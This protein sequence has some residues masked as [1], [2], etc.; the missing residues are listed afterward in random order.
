M[1]IF[2]ISQNCMTI[3]LFYHT[4]FIKDVNYDSIC[5][6]YKTNSRIVIHPS[7]TVDEYIRSVL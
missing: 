1:H 3:R 4:Y 2:V 6:L 7:F 5:V